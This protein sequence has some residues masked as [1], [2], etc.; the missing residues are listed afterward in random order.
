MKIKDILTPE[1]QCISPDATLAEAGA[2]MK[3]LDVGILLVCKNERVIGALT[4]RDIVVRAIAEGLDPKTI[5]VSEAMSN[6]IFY[7]FMDQDIQDAVE[8]MATGQIRRLPVLDRDKRLVG[9]V[10]LGDLAVRLPPGV[11]ATRVLRRVSQA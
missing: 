2:K 10:S 3:K 5:R 11:D 1:P 8:I 4:D 6:D 7:C 9:I